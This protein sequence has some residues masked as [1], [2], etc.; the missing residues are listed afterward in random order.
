M[1]ANVFRKRIVRN[2]LVTLAVLVLLYTV[3]GF[4]IVPRIVVSQAQEF[5]AQKL[6]R[7]LTIE[8][9]EFNPYTLRATIHGFKLME[10]KDAG[11]FAAFDALT[12]K[13]SWQSLFRFAP[14]VQQVLLQKPAVHI[15]REDARHYNFDQ[16]IADL[17]GP[18]K[19]P[20]KDPKPARFSVY[21]IEIDQG[22]VEFDDK[23]K[24][25]K[26]V[27]SDFKL[28]VPFIS[29]LPSQE[30][31]FVE[32]LLQAKIN[33]SPFRLAGKALPYAEPREATLEVNLDDIDVAH[34]LEYLPF[35]PQF[36][37]PSA[38][39]DLHL[40]ASFKQPKDRTPALFLSGDAALKSL[41]VTE[42]G[43][44]AVLTLPELAVK[45]GKSDI[46]EERIDIARVALNGL[47]LELAKEQDGRLN[48]QR[49]FD[50]SKVEEAPA[51]PQ[52]APA[53]KP[54]P[55]PEKKEAAAPGL[56]LAIDEFLI[57]GA[58][59]HYKDDAKATQAALDKFNLAVH[60]TRID[61][62]K[63]TVAVASIDSDSADTMFGVGRHAPVA[64]T[65][66]KSDAKND[67]KTAATDSKPPFLVTLNK[68]A[69]TNWSA[70]IDDRSHEKAVTTTLGPLS[71][72][73]QD[74]STAPKAV[75]VLDL[76]A[77]VN[78]TGQ[79]AI[80]GKFGFNPVHTDLTLDLKTVDLLGVQPYITDK[81]NLL[82]TS[83]NLSAKGGLK[84]DSD[85]DDALHGGFT[86]DLSLG[87]LATIDKI[88]GDDF[89][90]WKTLAL[91]G[92]D[93]K[94]APF[95][96]NIAQVGLNDFF[97]RVIVDPAGHINLQDI[98]RSNPGDKK[99]LTTAAPAATPA[100][101]APPPPPA[102]PA[103]P[104]PPIKVGKLVLGDGKVRYTDNFIT[105]HYTANLM[106]LGGQVGGLSSDPASR[107]SVDLHGQVNDA[108]LTI[109]GA[110]NP[111]KGNL[112]LDIKAKVTGMELAPLS[113]YSGRYVGYGIEEGK[114]SFEVAYQIEDRKLTAQN[115]L[116]LDQL[117]FGDKVDS[118]QATH[119]PVQFA[120]AL[121]RDR[122]GVIDLNL[123]IGGSLD[124]PDFSV[125]SII[126]KVI[127]NTITKAVTEP[128]ALLGS[129]FGGGKELST[130][131][132]DAGSH[133][134]NAE[135]EERLKGITKAL[136][137]R[138][139]LKLEITGWA[140]PATDRP[141]LKRAALNR[142][143]RAIKAKDLAARTAMNEDSVTVT[144][145]EYPALLARAYKAEKFDKPKNAIGLAKD[146][147]VAD[148]EKLMLDNTTVGDDELAALGNQR[149]QAIEQWLVTNGKIP[150]ERMFIIAAK[151]GPPVA[152]E[153]KDVSPGRVDFSLH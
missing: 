71:L 7:T 91:S 26:H 114:L 107:A 90:R 18:P 77:A 35:E 86:G 79:L 140:D 49:L 22:R 45:L 47:T 100:T 30:E 131:P 32:P 124:D 16:L 67:G 19:P 59:V 21:N 14:V 37:V 137:E 9:V 133:T 129:M 12:V 130:A 58:G 29:S 108:P 117:T 87:N 96:L 80:N 33:G 122:N 1:L 36:K 95:S 56:Q 23:P 135:T 103:T 39:L 46:F 88:T 143:L 116:I 123:P 4:F 62:G 93:V 44:K 119:L 136:N 92:V 118:P 63:R 145:Q 57:Q 151:V 48:L 34:Y 81:V 8:Q 78:K 5:G 148:M 139:A 84:L 142:K 127:V 13:L 149:S 3:F 132:F 27:V 83:A 53:P 126:V 10:A 150:G 98:V 60:K 85:S 120:V 105:P 42:Q 72:D 109:A 76:K 43:G 73:L 99:S 104:P 11:T 40:S 17:A 121:L 111:L 106:D 50:T 25:A 24:D 115:R 113:P 147:P 94:L 134:V 141:A 64:D 70:R 52:P 152:A 68:L 110:I 51:A 125:G 74:I 128:F 54:M 65:P 2:S 75:S 101:P 31:V 20:E 28:G 97:A 144:A 15:V 38:R 69:I 61:L 55:A 82:L 146:I 112:S 102:A 41:Q 6:H 138:P 89:L 153:G 66:A